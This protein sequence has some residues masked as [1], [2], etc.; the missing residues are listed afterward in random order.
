MKLITAIIRPHHL[1][2]LLE[3]LKFAPVEA[4]HVKEVKGFGRQKNVLD[5]YGSSEFTQAFL[6][7][8]EI[9]IWVES[10]RCEEVLQSIE[11]TCQT[12]RMGDGKI[13]V[14]NGVLAPFQDA[15]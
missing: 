6:P 10:A 13:L 8:V 2:E 12:G 9:N 1:E 4:L 15:L 7:K 5:R 3:A 14:V 11:R